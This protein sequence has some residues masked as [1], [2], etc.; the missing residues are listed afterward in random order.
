MKKEKIPLRAKGYG[1]AIW[2]NK[3]TRYDLRWISKSQQCLF[4]K[5]EDD[6]HLDMQYSF[7]FKDEEIFVTML[8]QL[9]NR[10]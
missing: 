1:Y 8:L 3:D 7:L 10:K 4:M 5:Y 9:E 6:L 2:R